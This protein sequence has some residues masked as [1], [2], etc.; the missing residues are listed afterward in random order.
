MHS[1]HARNLPF[2]HGSSD[3]TY[4]CKRNRINRRDTIE[5]PHNE[6]TRIA[7]APASSFDHS[8]K[9]KGYSK[10]EKRKK[11]ERNT[12]KAIKLR[13]QSIGVARRQ[14]VEKQNQA[15]HHPK[16]IRGPPSGASFPLLGAVPNCSFA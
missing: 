11:K 3:T 16:I 2:L 7:T 6:E 8:L 13:D 4:S 10:K 15:A 9:P 14:E 5:A 1:L 12:P